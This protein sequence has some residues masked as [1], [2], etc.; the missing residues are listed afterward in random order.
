LL[1]RARIFICFITESDG[2]DAG[3]KVDSIRGR[4][5]A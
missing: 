4:E 2:L 3:E 1:Q 5:T